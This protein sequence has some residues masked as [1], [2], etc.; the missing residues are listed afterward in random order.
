MSQ[1][2]EI[3]GIFPTIDYIIYKN[4]EVHF[5]ESLYLNNIRANLDK[6]TL[7]ILWA[8]EYKNSNS[9]FKSIKVL[10]YKKAELNFNWNEIINDKL[11][12]KLI[13][14]IDINM[15]ISNQIK[16]KIFFYY[17]FLFVLI[18]SVIIF[19]IICYFIFYL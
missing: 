12:N 2:V 5:I 13:N 16:P 17:N 8:K 1:I 11:C 9:M 15:I 4:K 6:D 3:Y 7:I 18:F 19:L 14:L 10:N